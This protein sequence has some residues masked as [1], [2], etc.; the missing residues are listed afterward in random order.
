MSRQSAEIAPRYSLCNA[1]ARA[2]SS[3]YG[4]GPTPG[5]HAGS[6]PPGVS[7]RLRGR[8]WPDVAAASCLVASA[9]LRKLCAARFALG[10]FLPSLTPRALARD[11][12]LEGATGIEYLVGRIHHHRF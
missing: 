6:S 5:L 7:T 1:N 10:I 11:T 9:A 3:R 12:V 8:A 4:N 2:G